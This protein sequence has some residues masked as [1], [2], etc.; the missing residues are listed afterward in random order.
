MV[1][2]SAANGPSERKYFYE[3][4][5]RS[6][7]ELRSMLDQE[8][9]ETET[10]QRKHDLWM[11]CPKCGEQLE[12]VEL[13]SIMVDKS[14]GCSGVFFDHGEWNLLVK[15]PAKSESFVNTLHSLLVGDEKSP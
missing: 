1:N 7:S 11:K 6:V 13:Q 12:E 2:F 15:S 4:D 3:Q 5:R 10:S 8:R 14:T 9:K